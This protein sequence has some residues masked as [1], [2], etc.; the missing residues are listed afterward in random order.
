M[1]RQPA[2]LSATWQVLDAPALLATHLDQKLADLEREN[3]D[4]DAFAREV[5]HEIRT[6]IG[7]VTAIAELLLQR[8][9]AHEESDL[10]R[11]LELQLRATRCMGETVQGLLDHA[12]AKAGTLNPEWVDL[13]AL[14][15]QL[16][17]ELPLASD[18]RA[19]RWTIQP[20]M[21]IHADPVLVALLMRNLLS[22]ALKYT[23]H[24]EHPAICVRMNTCGAGAWSVVVEDNG[25]GFDE[26][27][28]QRLFQ[29]FVRLHD[30][31]SFHGTGVGL[32]LVKRIVDRHGGWIAAHGR[33]DAGASFEFSLLP[34]A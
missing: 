12:R 30:P 6:P 9:R 5:A 21:Q 31:Q 15:H 29:P 20:G 33:V 19:V 13:S 10:C 3:R 2:Q 11:W 17:E 14:C 1:D 34:R 24:C 26:A 4:L 22:N 8:A 18:R 25:S 28:A 32:S 27:R 7:Q 23:A 16:R